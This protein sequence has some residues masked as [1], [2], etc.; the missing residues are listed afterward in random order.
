M[1]ELLP[2]SGLE[3]DVHAHYAL[4]WLDS[5]GLRA[6]MVAS[7]DG[8]ATAQGLSRGLQTP[9]DNR[10]FAALRDLADVVLVGAATALAE[11]YRPVSTDEARGAAR[12][13][14]GLR[15]E[16]PIALVSRTL[17]LD[18]DAPIFADAARRPIV[19]TTS[20]SDAGAVADIAE[21]LVAGDDQLDF[22][23]ARRQLASRGLTRVLCEGGPRLLGAVLAAGELD[24]LCLS[25]S[26]VLTG[27]SGAR[28]VDGGLA[29][30]LVPTH[31]QL[32]SVLEE[33]GALFLRYRTDRRQ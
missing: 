2:G 3:V 31:L 15:P 24:E 26:P 9:G 4:K 1:R 10:V 5:G 12:R 11:R 7:A 27:A 13:R 21:V 18:R 19:I 28:I 17:H 30:Q 16:L 6:N 29:A 20:T 14:Y 23:E 25:L 22:G 8:A 33:D 32:H